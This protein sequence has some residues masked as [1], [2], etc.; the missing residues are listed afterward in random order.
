MC[1]IVTSS[2]VFVIA[3]SI[4][5]PK[6]TKLTA[7]YIQDKSFKYLVLCPKSH[8]IRIIRCVYLTE[9]EYSTVSF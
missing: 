5:D 2:F 6:Y 7:M 9:H 8:K 1:F 3:I 4:L